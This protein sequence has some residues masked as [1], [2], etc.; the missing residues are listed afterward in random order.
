MG[1]YALRRFLGSLLIRCNWRED[2]RV[3]L[4]LNLEVGLM[5]DEFAFWEGLDQSTWICLVRS[6]LIFS[7]VLHFP[8]EVDEVETIW[9][10]WLPIPV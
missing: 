9:L 4:A 7:S 6:A 10:N 8:L 3:W 2:L 1:L 5:R